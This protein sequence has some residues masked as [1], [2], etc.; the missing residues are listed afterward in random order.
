[1]FTEVVFE[2]KRKRRRLY[3][4]R[5]VSPPIVVENTSPSGQ[6]L[7]WTSASTSLSLSVKSFQHHS[8]DATTCDEERQSYKVR[9]LRMLGLQQVPRFFRTRELLRKLARRADI[10]LS[11]SRLDGIHSFKYKLNPQLITCL[12]YNPPRN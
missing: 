8:E 7:S 1:M 4:E 5:S 2:Q 12:R 11:L 10:K 3:R 9:F 6:L